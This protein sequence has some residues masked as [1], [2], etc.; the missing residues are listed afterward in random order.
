MGIDVQKA[1]NGLWWMVADVMDCRRINPDIRAELG[2]GEWTIGIRDWDHTHTFAQCNDVSTKYRAQYVAVDAN[3]KLRRTEVYQA[4]MQYKF[5][6]IMGRARDNFNMVWER[7]T[8]DPLEGRRGG[9][10]KK[11]LMAQL[12][13]QSDTLDFKAVDL[14][15]GAI[16]SL[17]LLIPTPSDPILSRHLTSTVIID[18]VIEKRRSGAQ[19]DDHLFDCLKYILLLAMYLQLIPA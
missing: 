15:T 7:Q 11:N 14:L 13:F 6:P 18:G 10:N 17:R 4:A 19:T 3:Y 9:G 12:M 8:I 5:V 16:P 1:A 2:L